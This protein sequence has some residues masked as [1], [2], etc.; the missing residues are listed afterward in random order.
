MTMRISLKLLLV[1]PLIGAIGLASFFMQ[2]GSAENEAAADAAAAPAGPPPVEVVSAEAVS[3]RMTP[4][5]EVPGSVISVADSKIAAET[6][7]KIVTIAEVGDQVDSGDVVAEINPIDAQFRLNRAKSEVRK[8]ESQRNNVVSLYG[9]YESLGEDAGPSQAELDEVRSNIE[10]L[11]ADLSRARDEVREAEE[12][13]A[14][15]KIRAP[16]PGRVVE[17]LV[18]VGEYAQ[19]GRDVVR[20]VDTDRLEITAQV[21]AAMVFPLEPGTELSVTLPTGA[22]SSE[23]R[24]IVP[25]GDR[26]SRT[27]ELRAALASSDWLVG[28]PVRVTLQSGKASDVIAV[29]RDA[30]VLRPDEIYVMTIADGK[31]RRNIVAV[32]E[33]QDDLVA[34][35]GNISPG[36]LVIVRGAERLREGQT[37]SIK[38]D[39][40]PPNTT[41]VTTAK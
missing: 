40:S 12:N 14:R 38:S 19:P 3:V 2:S 20:L 25:V 39:D 18:Q 21:P 41:T 10:V 31:A 26:V 1:A 22:T 4:V 7:G 33:S 17:Q 36:D 32:G 30:L 16:F 11:E 5:T 24:A 34:V 15:T 29:P 13:L 8:L 9:R 6:A 28:T 23:L 27:M 35:E 37:V